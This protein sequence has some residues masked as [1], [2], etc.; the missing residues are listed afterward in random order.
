[1]N[2]ETDDN[3]FMPWWESY[4]R[5]LST[6]DKERIEREYY[7][8]TENTLKVPPVTAKERK[9]VIEVTD[10]ALQRLKHRFGMFTFRS[11]LSEELLLY[12]DE[13]IEDTYYHNL[14]MK[15]G[16]GGY[17]VFKKNVSEDGT[18]QFVIVT[19]T[20]NGEKV[21][22]NHRTIEADIIDRR[23]HFGW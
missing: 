3:Q 10:H 4:T 7:G 16:G 22:E 8:T 19:V 21:T 12:Q 2:F 17:I 13:E 11:I 1:M 15:D 5:T 20:S 14:K 23:F 9:W 6:E 18:E